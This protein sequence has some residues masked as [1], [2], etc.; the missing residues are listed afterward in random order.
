MH[1]EDIGATGVWIVDRKRPNEPL[2]TAM[3]WTN[4]AADKAGIRSGLL[5][6][7][8]DGTNVVSK[9]AEEVVRMVRGPVGAIVT[10]DFAD[11]A[12]TKTNKFML[13]RG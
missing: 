10:L 6:I 7:A 1:A 8:V 11:A 2:R 9:P 5:V 12:L 3:V 4:S 13:K